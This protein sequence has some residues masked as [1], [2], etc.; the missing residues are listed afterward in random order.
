MVRNMYL[1][2]LVSGFDSLP[3]NPPQGAFE[4]CRKANLTLIPNIL[5]LILAMLDLKE[6]LNLQYWMVWFNKVSEVMR[7]IEGC[8]VQAPP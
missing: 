4:S 8:L 1:A 3:S 2:Q 7:G 6:K 5:A